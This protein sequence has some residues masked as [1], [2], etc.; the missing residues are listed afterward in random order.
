V[1]TISQ[2]ELVHDVI[3]V[4]NRIAAGEQIVIT[5]GGRPIAEL[6]PVAPSRVTPRPFGLAAGEFVVP[7]DFDCPLPE[8]LL[9][10]FE[11]Q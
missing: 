1:S 11:G 2:Q 6:R 5:R 4:L 7:D 3:S 9:R 10:E 8:Q